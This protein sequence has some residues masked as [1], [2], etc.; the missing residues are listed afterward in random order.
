MRIVAE[1]LS[2]TERLKRVQLAM[3]APIAVIVAEALSATE[4][5][6]PDTESLHEHVNDIGGRG[7][8]RDRAIETINDAYSKIVT[9]FKVA[10]ALSATERL[11]L[12]TDSG[13]LN[14]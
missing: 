3:S 2:A 11:K 4:R 13:V 5:L 1:A 8:E 10:E 12:S 14:Q 6:K 7:I 9:M